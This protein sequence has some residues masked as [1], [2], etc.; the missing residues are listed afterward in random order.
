MLQPRAAGHR[1]ASGWIQPAQPARGGA[2]V[3][4]RQPGSPTFAV[5]AAET[6]KEGGPT[7]RGQGSKRYSEVFH[8]NTLASQVPREGWL[9]KVTGQAAGSLA[10]RCPPCRGSCGHGFL[11]PPQRSSQ[12]WLC[13][14]PLASPAQARSDLIPA[15]PRVEAPKPREQTEWVQSPRSLSCAVSNSQKIPPWFSYWGYFQTLHFIS[16]KDNN[17]GEKQSADST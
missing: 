4:P 7:K 3:G 9:P 15:S 11:L 16:S 1:E 2:G 8:S 12:G 10:L 13:T 17:E 5:Q 6:A 14:T